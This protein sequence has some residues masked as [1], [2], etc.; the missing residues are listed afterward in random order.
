MPSACFSHTD[1]CATP[2]CRRHGGRQDQA[3]QLPGG[4]GPQTADGHAVEPRDRRSVAASQQ[5]H[6]SRTDLRVP[7]G[8]PVQDGQMAVL[9]GLRHR[10]H[11]QLGVQVTAAAGA[12]SSCPSGCDSSQFA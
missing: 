3:A 4:S 2:A 12:S 1:A 8:S 10:V 11:S 9:C 7:P 6:Q 5:G